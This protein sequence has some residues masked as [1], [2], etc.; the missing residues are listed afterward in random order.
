MMV[1]F[2]FV[3]LVQWPLEELMKSNL[4]H[5]YGDAVDFVFLAILE[6]HWMFLHSFA[7]V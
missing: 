3:D 6:V 5:Q 2:T 7:Y 4:S 1:R